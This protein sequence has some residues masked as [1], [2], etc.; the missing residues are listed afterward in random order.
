MTAV[1]GWG[2][3]CASDIVGLADVSPDSPRTGFGLIER[4][5][6]AVVGWGQPCGSDVVSLMD[7]SP[8]SPQRALAAELVMAL[9]GV[10]TALWFGRSWFAGREP[11]QSPNGLWL[12]ERKGNGG[13]G[14]ATALRFGHCWFVGRQPGQSPHGLW[15]IERKATRCG[16]GTALRFGLCW[17]VDLSPDSPETALAAFGESA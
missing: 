16:V 10:G 15:L 8:D 17:L 11:G 5:A 12:I 13:G 3:P 7:V 2:Q 1:V 6:T 9:H 14:V 4:K